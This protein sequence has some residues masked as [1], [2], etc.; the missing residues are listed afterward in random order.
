MI[1]E[2]ESR[3]AQKQ[4]K[5]DKREWRNTIIGGSFC[6]V[7]ALLLFILVGMAENSPENWGI[8]GHWV[9][10]ALIALHIW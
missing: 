8:L 2:L 7:M 10:K 6:A 5:Q 4:K 3:R 1:M 9:A